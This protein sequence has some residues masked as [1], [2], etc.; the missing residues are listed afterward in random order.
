MELAKLGKKGQ[1]SIP[2]TVL[3]RAGIPTGSPVLV[4]ATD[5][6]AIVIR[7]AAVYPLETYSAERVAEFL[8]GDEMSEED[9]KR[10]ASLLGSRR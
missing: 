1:L 9:R 5:D 10:L 3:E 6:G 4:E 7:A 8:A 2:R